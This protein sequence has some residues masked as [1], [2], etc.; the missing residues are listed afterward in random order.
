MKRSTL[1]RDLVALTQ[2]SGSVGDSPDL[3]TMLRTAI[4]DSFQILT[5]TRARE[6]ARRH[7]IFGVN[8]V[9]RLSQM[10]LYGIEI[11][12]EVV[13]GRGV[14]FVHSL[15]IIIGGD[16]KIGDRVRF[17]GNNTVGTAKDNGYPV[18]GNDVM[19]GCGARI[20]GPVHVGD[21]AQIG[22]NAVVLTDIPAGAVALGIPAHVV[23]KGKPQ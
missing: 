18:I 22:A 10:A 6:V 7:H 14:Y 9:L 13:L 15:G 8:R 21:G 23:K 11:G 2:A 19:I 17:M 12:N 4:L 5:M 3:R 20:L 1:L 16:S